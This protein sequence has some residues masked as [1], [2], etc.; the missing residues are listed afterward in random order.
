V[1]DPKSTPPASTG[2]VPP[3]ERPEVKPLVEKAEAERV[4]GA[5]PEATIKSGADVAGGGGTKTL[6]PGPTPQPKP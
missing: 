3:H 2:G 5:P 4:R 1:S 6:E